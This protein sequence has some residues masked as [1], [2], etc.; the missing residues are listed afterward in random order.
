MKNKSIISAICIL[1]LVSL[2][3]MMGC[4]PAQRPEPRTTPAPGQ[5]DMD[6]GGI[7]DNQNVPETGMRSPDD[8][9]MFTENNRP[10]IDD[11]TMD[12]RTMDNRTMDN[13]PIADDRTM[14]NR[15]V[16]DNMGDRVNRIIREVE[17]IKDV[18][19]AAVVITERTALVGIDLTSGTKGKLNNQIKREVEDAVKRADKDITRVSVTADPDVFT[20]IQNI[21][22]DIDKGRPLSGFGREI[23]EIMRRITPGA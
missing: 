18:R 12:N 7:M 4:R 15:T 21:A 23:E 6:R 14:D 10:N 22:R 13:R 1:L 17:S 5:N 20:R 9:R 16:T 11:R 2:A 19:R 8:N 3:A